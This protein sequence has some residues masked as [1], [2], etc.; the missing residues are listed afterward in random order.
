MD[1]NKSVSATFT[2]QFSLAT[3]TV[4]G[5]SVFLNPPGG[6]Y[7]SLTVVTLTATADSGW[8]F[9][10]W[11]GD[12]TGIANPDSLVMDGNKSVTAAFTRQF[13]LIPTTVGGGSVFLNPPG[14]FYDSLT[15]VALTA[16]PDSGWVFAGWS[17]DL[18][19]TANPDS[20]TVNGNKSVNATF[21]RQFSL[22]TNTVGDGSI[23]LNPPGGLYDSSTVVT[24]TATADSGWI[25]TGWSGDLSGIA[26]PDSL[27]MD[28][29]KSVT[30][31]FIKRSPLTVNAKVFLEGPY[32]SGSMNTTLNTNGGLPL[33]QP[34]YTS[35]WNHNGAEV[36]D[37]LPPA[38]VDWVLVG[39]R[40]SPAGSEIA[41]RAALLQTDGSITDTSGSGG[42]KFENVIYGDYYLVIY[43][44][45]HLAVMSS[46]AITLTDS[47]S[48][49]DFTA[50]PGQASGSNSMTELE[51]GIYGMIAADGNADGIVSAADKE[52]VWRLENGTQWSYSKSGDF[53]LD[54]GI[55]VLDLNYYWRLHENAVSGVPDAAA[56]K[57]SSVNTS[58]SA[59]DSSKRV[60]ESQKIRD[61][62]ESKKR[63]ATNTAQ[64]NR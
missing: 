51:P 35:P 47:G 37:S 8:V 33:A 25:F 28:T 44:R 24:L 38:V 43:H 46:T 11:S 27:V 59:N 26:N 61:E 22:T 29:N 48:L 62:S 45:N 36:V 14:G 56:A 54:G 64:K 52:N 17:G 15:V 41:L 49:Y 30:A 55:D 6:F 39:L 42:V 5:G 40:E 32:V 60:F 31:T 12:L 50:G 2:R 10:G 20:L 19:G 53:N 1:S 7:D 63:N 21:T 16:V 3:T 18:S 13:S 57:I 58:G 23:T 9:A 4:G 34:Y